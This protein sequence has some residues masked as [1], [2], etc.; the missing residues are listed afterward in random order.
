MGIGKDADSHQRIRPVTE[1][2]HPD[3]LPNARTN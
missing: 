3:A 2:V 1:T